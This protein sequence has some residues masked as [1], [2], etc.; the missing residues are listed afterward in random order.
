MTRFEV[1]DPMTT[2]CS[3]PAMDTFTV[4]LPRGL[5][6]RLFG[7]NP[8]VRT[9]DRVE[10]LIVVLAFVVSMLALPVAATVGTA[11]YESRSRVYAEQA[12]TRQKVTATVTGESDARRNLSSP[13]ATAPGRWFVAGTEHTGMVVVPRAAKPGERVD[14]WVDEQGSP[15]GKPALSALDEAVATGAA[16]W[17]GVV[18]VAGALVGLTH[19]VADQKRH[20]GWQRDFD[21]MVGNSTAE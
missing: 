12:Q 3:D 6:V 4:R 13:T 2:P 14:I 7:R 19:N 9:A 11:V 21:R 15:V 1:T 17:F 18:I 20:T 16:L 5:I 8:L 10:A